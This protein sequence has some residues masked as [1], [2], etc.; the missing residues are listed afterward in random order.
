M[1]LQDCYLEKGRKPSGHWASS[2]QELTPALR[3]GQQAGECGRWRS[4]QDAP[5]SS[6]PPQPHAVLLSLQQPRSLSRGRRGQGLHGVARVRLGKLKGP[7][8]FETLTDFF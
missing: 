3:K 6:Q 7:G 4:R 1:S 2:R 5:C 8:A